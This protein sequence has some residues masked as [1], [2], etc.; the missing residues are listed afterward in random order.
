MFI[1]IV[2]VE[3]NRVSK[4][5]RFATNQKAQ[6]HVEVYG[7]FVYETTEAVPSLWIVGEAVTI[8]PFVPQLTYIEQRV[9]TSVENGGYGTEG[10]RAEVAF[11]AYEAN[12]GTDTEKAV[13]AAK[14]LYD[15]AITAR[16]NFPKP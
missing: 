4:E 2:K 11:N 15:L 10:Q 3:N 1:A 12:L 16:N 7:G 9:T 14:A 5:A 13:A 6:D 8:V